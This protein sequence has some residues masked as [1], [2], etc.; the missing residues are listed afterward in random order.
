MI[1]INHIT[2]NH[3]L[4]IAI[5]VLLGLCIGSFL[6]VVIYRLPIMLKR[7]LRDQYHEFLSIDNAPLN[8]DLYSDFTIF[9]LNFP[10]SHCP[11]CSSRIK[12]WEN[13]PLVSY[14][15]LGRKCSSCENKISVRY[16]L[17]ELINGV[18]TGLIVYSFGPNWM[19]LSLLILIWSLVAL[20]L[21]DFDHQI[22]PDEITIPILWLG[23]FTNTFELSSLISLRDS[24][25]G[26]MAGYISL[27]TFNY[28]YKIVRGKDGMGYGDF[29]LFSALGAWLGWKALLPLIVLA[30]TS[31]AIL[32]ILMIIFL[33]KNKLT[34]IPFGPFLSGAGVILILWEPQINTFFYTRFLTGL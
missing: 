2:S 15:V 16:P 24:V 14:F 26:A 28:F 4:L 10:A 23:I 13:I 5:S 3:F 9:N 12:P 34:P 22:L 33:Q 11:N 30:S 7:D 32:G 27:W 8:N 1:A 20:T 29:K 31:G 18:L 19:T 17:I 25:I 21:I 6:N